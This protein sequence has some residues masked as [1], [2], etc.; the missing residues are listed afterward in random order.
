MHV[1]SEYI[2]LLV[3]RT[4][5][6]VWLRGGDL[7]GPIPRVNG[8]GLP[9]TYPPLSAVLF[10]PLALLPVGAAEC[11]VLLCSMACLAVTLWLV[12]IRI[13]PAM[14]PRTRAIGL[15]AVV[16]VLGLSEPV[17]ETYAFGQIN[18][19]LMLAVTL[20]TLVRK[21]FWPRGLLIGIA[22]S[23]K[24]I[25]AAYLLYF[26]IRRDWR[27]CGTIVASAGGAIGLGFVLLPRDSR[28]YWLHTMFETDRIGPPQYAGNQS[29]KA[30]AFR[31]GF[32]D[33]AGT[34]IWIVLAAIA[35]GLAAVVMKRLLD[36]GH[37]VAALMV[38]AAAVLLASPVSWSHHWVWI[39]PAL[40]VG[41]AAI[42]E[43]PGAGA[44]ADAAR[45]RR[46]WI[47]I[48]LLV[49]TVFMLGPQWTLPFRGNREMGWALWEQI[50]GSTYVL[51]TFAALVIAVVGYRPAGSRK[52]ASAAE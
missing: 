8:M 22:V 37:E 28:E 44:A 26:L 15:V 51:V 10:A 25:P 1:W 43:L 11:L 4:G 2:D 30:F 27:T 48:Y 49:L 23:V 3:Y 40:L 45:R 17:R 32:G 36:Q 13:R 39:G 7:Y 34:V 38:N 5:A 24:L 6:R 41:A 47:A 29:L 18:L 42:A 9:F 20:D 19:V 33:T 16:A 35:I 21:P 12:S 50:V 14:D 52:A 46:F 31:L